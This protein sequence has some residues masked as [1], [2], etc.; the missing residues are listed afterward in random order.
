MPTVREYTLDKLVA[1]YLERLDAP[2]TLTDE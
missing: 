2:G 1:A